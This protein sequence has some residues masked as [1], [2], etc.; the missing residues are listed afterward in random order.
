MSW[1]DAL[2]G[3]GAAFALCVLA[4]PLSA[5]VRPEQRP[6]GVT[7]SAIAWGQAL[8][9]GPANCSSCHG[10]GGRG[11][12]RG[13]NITGALWLHGPGTYESLI[14]WVKR[15]VPAS[16]TYTGEAMPACGGSP[17]NALDIQAVAAY[18]WSISHPPQPPPASRRRT[19][20]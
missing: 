14:E 1:M 8:F 9:H 5:Q 16:R 19:P 7:D 18:V 17:M 13:P 20:S 4:S 15:G 12:D 2:G 6:A 11:A 10:D 3:V